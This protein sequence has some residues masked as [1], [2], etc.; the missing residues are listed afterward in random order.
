M[1]FYRSQ[2]IVQAA[3]MM[4]KPGLP[5]RVVTTSASRS[6]G[7]KLC[8]SS[9]FTFRTGGWAWGPVGHEASGSV[10]E[11]VLDEFD[12]VS[13]TAQEVFGEHVTLL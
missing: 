7:V 12:L 11:D 2:L 5:T 9:W 1:V 4:K 8:W 6:R 10:S 13:E 3:M